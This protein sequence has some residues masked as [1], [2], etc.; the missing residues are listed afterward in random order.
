MEAYINDPEPYLKLRSKFWE[1]FDILRNERISS[2][3]YC[4]ALFLLSIVKDKIFNEDTRFAKPQIKEKIAFLVN[5]P[6]LGLEGKYKDIYKVFEPILNAISPEAMFSLICIYLDLDSI[7]LSG[8][9]TELFD[10]TLNILAQSE[11]KYRGIEIH[12]VE[13]Y[14]LIYGF[15]N[16]PEKSLVFNPFAGM[17]SYAIQLNKGLNYL[18]QEADPLTWAIG[19]LR[20]IA[21]E[22]PENFKFLCQNSISNWPDKSQQFD[23]I[24]SNPPYNLSLIDPK[25]L[26]LHK[27]STVEQTLIENGIKSLNSAGKLI[28]V[29]PK[30]FLFRL[31]QKPLM[32]LLVDEDLLDTLLFLPISFI[33]QTG[34]PLVILI[35]NKKKEKPGKVRFIKTDK[36]VGKNNSKELYLN[37]YTLNGFIHGQKVDEKI[38]RFVDNRKIQELDYN[39]NIHKYFQNEIKLAENERLVK[40]KEI[41]EPIEGQKDNLPDFGKL[42]RIKNLKDHKMDFLLKVSDIDNLEI[43][44]KN[45]RQF[46][47]SALIVALRW[48]SL[49]P[50]YFNFD[51]TPIYS[52]QH[53]L[54][55][56]VNDKI[57]DYNYI[58]NELHAD[59]VLTQLEELRIGTTIPFIRKEDFLEVVVKMTSMQ[60]QR[61]KLEG[62]RQ[63]FLEAKENELKL[64]KEIL[65]I[66]EDK[67]KEFASL[68]H[69][70]RQYLGALK[71]N[72]AGTKKF[73]HKR[74][75]QIISLN[76]IYSIKLNQT[77]LDHL[78]SLQDT[79]EALSKLLEIDSYDSPKSNVQFLNLIELVKSAHVRFH[80]E[81]FKFELIVNEN[82]FTSDE[83]TLIPM[84]EINKEDFMKLFSNIVSNAVHHGFKNTRGNIIR[85]TIS[86]NSFEEKCILEVSNNGIPLPD[87]FTLNLLTTRGEKTTDSEG[88]GIGGADIKDI[89]SKHKGQLDLI[90]DVHSA[91]PVTYKISFSISKTSFENEI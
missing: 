40:L 66:K 83:K 90:N 67:F 28:A 60:E 72:V 63:T 20:M 59:Y 26:T 50:T 37:S 85:S 38:M 33:T 48:S 43:G 57:S 15:F 55:F 35:I 69:T 84:I 6:E 65:G 18:G 9:Y 89:I 74:D 46:K 87:K 34:T 16:L 70:Y 7:T 68:K 5:S 30:D 31:E 47:E 19:A 42:V 32:Q 12:S 41:L 8:N 25:T 79:I 1:V 4:V 62:T 75:G 71:S 52:D 23:L 49:K 17:A 64:Q 73:L 58:I 53:I 88:S 24:V 76:D 22:R 3:E 21:Y 10:Y 54:F 81:L 45:V 77:L 80:Q 11:G 14:N 56:R 44:K 91:F 2:E 86:Y 13:I 61:A 78:N 27:K 51:G 82:S 29:L 36:F 39:L